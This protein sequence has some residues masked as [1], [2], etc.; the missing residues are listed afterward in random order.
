MF[1]PAATTTATPSPM[2]RPSSRSTSNLSVGALSGISVAITF[3]IMGLFGWWFFWYTKRVRARYHDRAGR[4]LPSLAL[5][6]QDRRQDEAAAKLK[7]EQEEKSRSLQETKVQDVI[8]TTKIA[9]ATSMEGRWCQKLIPVQTRFS[10]SPSLLP[11][12]MR[13]SHMC[14]QVQQ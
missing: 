1:Q 10:I 8:T 9:G 12:Y 6:E 14:F 3:V 11:L 2:P 5:I 13:I 4:E 7:A